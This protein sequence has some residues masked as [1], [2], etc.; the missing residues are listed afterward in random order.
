MLNIDNNLKSKIT[1]AVTTIDG[2]SKNIASEK[3]KVDSNT[4]AFYISIE[5]YNNVKSFELKIAEIFSGEKITASIITNGKTQ[6]LLNVKKEITAKGFSDKK[7]TSYSGKYTIK[8]IT[9]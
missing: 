1:A 8:L 7:E 5:D 4:G 9:R 6:N 2:E 3:V